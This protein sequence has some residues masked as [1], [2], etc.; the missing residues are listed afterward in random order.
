MTLCIGIA[1]GVVV[2]YLDERFG[3]P[4]VRPSPTPVLLPDPPPPVEAVSPDRMVEALF[5][6]AEREDALA[7]AWVIIDEDSV[8]TQFRRFRPMTSA[9]S[10]AEVGESIGFAVAEA[11]AEAQTPGGQVVED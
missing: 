10:P 7:A 9:A 3:G 1:I 8:T 5:A 2:P 11:V 4:V 6:Q